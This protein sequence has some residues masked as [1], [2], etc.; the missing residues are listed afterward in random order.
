MHVVL[1]AFVTILFM[2]PIVCIVL[3]YFVLRNGS[4]V[5][6]WA[7]FG[8]LMTLAVWT[9]S[10][11]LSAVSTTAVAANFWAT[12][13]RFVGVSLSAIAYFCFVQGYGRQEHVRRIPLP[14]LLIIPSVTIIIAFTNSWH[15]LFV[16]SIQ[17][18]SYGSFMFRETWSAGPWFVVHSVYSYCFL[19]Y[20]GWRM[21]KIALTAAPP[22]QAQAR[23]MLAATTVTIILNIV[24]LLHILPPPALDLTSIALLFTA[25]SFSIATFRYQMLRIVPLAGEQLISAISHAV[26]VVDM[27]ERLLHMNDAARVLCGIPSADPVAGKRVSDLL[28]DW[29][30]G[31]DSDG[32]AVFDSVPEFRTEDDR[33]FRAAIS[34]IIWP[35]SAQKIGRIIVLQEFTDLANALAEK[36]RLVTMLSEREQ[37]LEELA[38]TDPLTGLKNRRALF[39]AAAHEFATVKRY[40]GQLSVAIA[41]LDHFKR[42]NDRYGHSTGDEVLKAVATAMKNLTRKMDIVARIGGEEFCMLLPETSAA[43]ALQFVERLRTTVAAI[44]IPWAGRSIAVTVSIGVCE[45]SPDLATFDEFLSFADNALYQAKK[46]GRARVVLWDG[47]HEMETGGFRRVSSVV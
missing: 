36:D 14:V 11:A 35:R 41:D 44:R 38:S 25:V 12:N 5:E 21:L 33:S 7:V 30:H 1:P 29:L 13:V 3:G 37:S 47:E 42:I 16:R 27:E 15:G 10:S 40:G 46:E 28:P 8:L 17:Y 20:G 9:G 4:G 34:P 39:G 19:V 6:S 31:L 18:R 24:V 32:P 43:Q 23:L 26:F 22:W 2:S 45:F